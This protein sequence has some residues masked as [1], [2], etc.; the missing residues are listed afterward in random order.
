MS[1]PKTDTQCGLAMLADILT[2][3]RIPLTVLFC[4]S[5][6]G[7]P[8]VLCSTLLFIIIIATDFFDGRAAKHSGTCTGYGEYFD[9]TADLI[10]IVSSCLV[11]ALKGIMPLLMAAVVGLKFAEFIL[12][13]AAMSGTD[14]DLKLTPDRLGRYVA[15]AFYVLPLFA[16]YAWFLGEQLHSAVSA[17]CLILT[18]L[19]VLSSVLRCRTVWQKRRPPS[20]QPR[21]TPK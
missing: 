13:S 10:F 16:V 20:A 4:L 12:T 15:A 9:C 19:A 14:I 11:L 6:A 2:F 21:D 18:V 17:V 3:L 7:G 1:G 5:L 8:D